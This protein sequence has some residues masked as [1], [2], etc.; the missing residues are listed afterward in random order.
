MTEPCRLLACLAFLLYCPFSGAGM[1]A[2]QV[3]APL[4]PWVD[5][6][7][8]DTADSRCPLVYNQSGQN[9]CAW[10]SLLTLQVGDQS[11]EFRQLWTVDAESWLELPG[12]SRFWPQDVRLDGY[13][14]I[15]LERDGRPALK[16]GSGE[17][18]VSGQF[19]WSTLPDYLSLPADTA[20]LSLQIKG[21]AI[22]NPRFEGGG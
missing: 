13:P 16:A 15:V 22:P 21:Q 9:R 18:T 4:Q 14:S 2:N 8:Y 5:W 20:L 17:H 7:L 10:P 1:P 3:P 19:Y 11:G 12:D 6:V